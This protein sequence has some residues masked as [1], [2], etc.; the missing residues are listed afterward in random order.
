MFAPGLVLD[1]ADL[2]TELMN[3]R[4]VALGVLNQ[5]SVMP[6]LVWRAGP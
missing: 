5:F 6:L 4:R 2:K 1:A 3:P